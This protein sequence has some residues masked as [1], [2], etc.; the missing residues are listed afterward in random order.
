MYLDARELP[1][2]K[3]I[4]ADFCVI[5]AGIAGIIIALE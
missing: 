1:Q 2:N 3:L 5:G 4:K